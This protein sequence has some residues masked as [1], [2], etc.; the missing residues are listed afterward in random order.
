MTID[1]SQHDSA[2]TQGMKTKSHSAF[3]KGSKLLAFKGAM[4]L[5]MRDYKIILCIALALLILGTLRAVYLPVFFL[6]LFTG[7]I[8]GG[9]GGFFDFIIFL[10]VFIW[11]LSIIFLPVVLT[12]HV[13]LD[14]RLKAMLQ[15]LEKSS[16]QQDKSVFAQTK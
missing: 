8:Y 13:F 12:L 5:S 16:E 9:G 14:R 1:T 2:Q 11:G 15:K 3:D 6:G 10:P 4:I 7:E